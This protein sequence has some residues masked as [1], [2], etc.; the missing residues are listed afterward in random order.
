MPKPIP[1]QA[2]HEQLIG[3]M[4]NTVRA[5]TKNKITFHVPV[6]TDAMKKEDLTENVDAVIKKIEQTLERGKQN[7]DSIYIKTTMGKSVRVM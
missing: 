5:R 2:N 3:R 4:R 6:G 1:P 7:I